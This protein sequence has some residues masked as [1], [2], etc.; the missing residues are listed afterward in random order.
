MLLLL[1]ACTRGSDTDSSTDDTHGETGDTEP[2]VAGD[3]FAVYDGTMRV[4]FNVDHELQ[5]DVGR[6]QSLGKKSDWTA[7]ADFDGDG[8]DDLWQLADGSGSMKI[9]INDGT[10]WSN[11][12]D[13]EPVTGIG[14]VR[15]A[16]AGDFTGDDKD[17][18][19]LF[20]N[21]GRFVVLPNDLGEFHW[22]EQVVTDHDV[23]TGTGEYSA[24]DFDGD[25]TDDL[26][27]R[28]G[29]DISIYKVD[30]GVPGELLLELDGTGTV[31][32]VGLDI[33]EDGDDELGLW[34][35]STMKL[36]RNE[37]GELA[38][39][40]SIFFNKQGTPLAGQAR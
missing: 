27:H 13:F 38:E 14:S 17:D 12:P 28:A 15:P 6:E 2:L 5:T 36:F 25:G 4:F 3:D 8:L 29:T 35:G 10:A 37:E 1:M 19:A 22:D 30:A 18:L 34:T 23:L 40:E 32:V 11:Q 16:F 33:D 9:W 26:V 24:A 20:N 39:P 7:W 31:G 21:L